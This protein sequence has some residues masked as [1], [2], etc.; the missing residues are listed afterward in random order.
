MKQTQHLLS[1]ASQMIVAVLVQWLDP[2]NYWF[3]ISKLIAL[4]V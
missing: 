1:D 3:N 2:Q 4:N